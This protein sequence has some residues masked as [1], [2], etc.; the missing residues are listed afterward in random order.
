MILEAQKK[1]VNDLMSMIV[2]LLSL[3]RLQNH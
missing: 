1:T 2:E 3:L